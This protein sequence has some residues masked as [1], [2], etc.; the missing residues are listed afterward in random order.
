MQQF[1]RKNKESL[2][3]Y[4]QVI[5]HK[6]VNLYEGQSVFIKASPSVYYFSRI[7]AEEAYSSGAGYVYIENDDLSLLRQRVLNQTDEDLNFHPDFQKSIYRELI[8]ED[9]AFIRIENLEGFSL[10]ADISSAKVSSLQTSL[11]KKMDFF[12][13][14]ILA[15]KSAWCV[16]CAPEETWAQR[17]LGKDAS[18][19]EFWDLLKPILRLD[20]E[21]PL[22]AWEEHGSTLQAR[23]RVLNEKNIREL[24]I[25]DDSTD[26]RI[27]IPSSARWIGGPDELPDKRQFFP[28]IPTEEVFTLPERNSVNGSVRITRPAAVLNRLVENAILHFTDGKVTGFTADKGEDILQEYFAIDEGAAYCGE[29]ALVGKD[30]PIFQTEKTFH[31]T[32]YDENAACHL[33]LGAGYTKCLDTGFELKTDEEKLSYGCNVSLVHTDLMISSE[34]TRITAIDHAGNTISIMENGNLVI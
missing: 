32:L 10:L 21:N 31:S 13:K 1:E 29:I 24:H 5:L 11:R 14:H 28:N 26:L 4:A 16:V 7:L 30:S 20:Y 27:E 9:W 19:Q 18:I 25:Q 6:G 22:K 3:R 2:K 8:D 17:V 33:A 15:D 23:C 34:K 12:F